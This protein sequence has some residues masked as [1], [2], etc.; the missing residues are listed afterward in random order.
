M[1]QHYKSCKNTL[2]SYDHKK[3]W[4]TFREQYQNHKFMNKDFFLSPQ[5]KRF[6]SL[7]QNN[8]CKRRAKQ[9]EMQR[10]INSVPN[11]HFRYR[12][13]Q[14]KREQRKERIRWCTWMASLSRSALSGRPL[15]NHLITSNNQTTRCLQME[16]FPLPPLLKLS[17]QLPVLFHSASGTSPP[18]LNRST[19]NKRRYC[20][21]DVA[22]SLE[23]F[24]C[25]GSH[26]N[27]EKCWFMPFGISTQ[28]S[29]PSNIYSKLLKLL[30]AYHTH[31]QHNSHGV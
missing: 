23:Y 1:I 20:I 3:L 21:L 31:T 12:H 28:V 5:K 22:A 7:V 9:N 2:N 8:T 29:Q 18:S 27:L 24:W 16:N 30:P 4:S 19:T 11:K 14:G 15:Q 26:F 13:N 6:L 17:I 25:V 10:Q